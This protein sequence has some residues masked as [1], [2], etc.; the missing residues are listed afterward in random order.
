MVNFEDENFFF[1][2]LVEALN[3]ALAYAKGEPNSCTESTRISVL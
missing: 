1:E 2:T 3:D